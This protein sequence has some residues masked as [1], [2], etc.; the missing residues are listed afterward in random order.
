MNHAF[1]CLLTLL[2]SLSSPAIKGNADFW[3][4]SLVAKS[5]AELARELGAA[6]E[7][8]SGSVGPKTRIPSLTG[9]ASYRVPDELI[10]NVLL[11]DAKNVAELRLT[12]GLGS[13][14]T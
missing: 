5:G 6:G 1:I 2:F 8:M 12:T 10:S 7:E 13:E 3:H 4:S 9:T 14:L 11:R